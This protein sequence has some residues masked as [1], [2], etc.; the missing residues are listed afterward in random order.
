MDA[1]VVTLGQ[2]ALTGGWRWRGLCFDIY[3]LPPIQNTLTYTIQNVLGNQEWKCLLSWY[4]NILV[5]VASRYNS[6]YL[7]MRR[8]RCERFRGTCNSVECMY[9]LYR[10][11]V[12]TR[13]LCQDTTS[14]QDCPSLD[15][16]VGQDGDSVDVSFCAL[17]RS[18]EWTEWLTCQYEKS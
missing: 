18:R 16:H 11:P 10:A 15:V 5:E 3:Y 9:L 12:P 2:L 17:Y 4:F 1:N 14:A 13:S 6:H 7:N 8:R